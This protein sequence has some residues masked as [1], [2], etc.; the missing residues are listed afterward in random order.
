MPTN[1]PNQSA[2]MTSAHLADAKFVTPAISNIVPYPS[3]GYDPCGTKQQHHIASLNTPYS[4]QQELQSQAHV[5]DKQF[6]APNF[7]DDCTSN[8]AQFGQP[9]STSELLRSQVPIAGQKHHLVNG[10]SGAGDELSI[11]VNLSRSHVANT[12][13]AIQSTVSYNPAAATPFKTATA[14]ATSFWQNGQDPTIHGETQ[15]QGMAS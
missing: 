11:V 10:F 14:N 8:Y 6:S 7:T 2:P 12:Y 9:I 15:V 4:H 13:G 1:D 3:F 5:Q